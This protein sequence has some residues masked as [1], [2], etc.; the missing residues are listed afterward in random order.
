MTPD[1][2]PI[3]RL[4]VVSRDRPELAERALTS[5]IA[6]CGESAGGLDVLVV[7]DSRSS[8]TSG[9]YEETCRRIAASSGCRVRHVTRAD[10]RRVAARIAARLAAVVAPEVV[11]AA[12]VGKDDD[13]FTTGAARNYTLLDAVGERLW[14]IDD[15]VQLPLR[16]MPGAAGDLRVMTS[17][18]PTTLSFFETREAAL[19]AARVVSPA[20]SPASLLG[21]WLGRAEEI[22][23]NRDDHVARVVTTGMVGDAGMGS[24]LYRLLLGGAA[25]ERLLAAWDAV[26]LSRE[27]LR[28][29][30]Q[31]TL[32][33]HPL[34]MLPCAALDHR[35]MLPPFLPTGRNSDGAFAIVLRAFDPRSA[36]VHLPWVAPH[37]PPA[38]ASYDEIDLIRTA[39]RPSPQTLLTMALSAEAR[40]LNGDTAT[41][42]LVAL[43]ARLIELGEL[44]PE[45]LAGILRHRALAQARG[46]LEA[47]ARARAAHPGGPPRWVADLDG[48]RV[49]LGDAIA[50]DD[51]PPGAADPTLGAALVRAGR[52][53]RA[54]PDIVTLGRDLAMD[55]K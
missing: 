27:L 14:T 34:L 9:V 12:L 31:P 5:A 29:V 33:L 28:G 7:D 11:E 19:G 37:V 23:A 4:A 39:T 46:T 36:I 24:A 54:W 2:E 47:L 26:R 53:F 13:R 15:D 1:G 17:G 6:S 16:A 55:D 22:E 30:T 21:A 32:S 51:Y 45:V 41:A 18:D 3:R 25:K 20:P 48:A 40:D 10:R 8:E 52:V 50:R 43:G 44:P 42:R 35:S 49:A 38:R